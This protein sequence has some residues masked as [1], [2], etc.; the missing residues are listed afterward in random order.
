MTTTMLDALGL[1]QAT[2]A[3]TPYLVTGTCT[4]ANADAALLTFRYAGQ[5]VTGVIPV[6]EQ[7]PGTVW[8]PGTVATVLLCEPAGTGVPPRLSAIRTELVTETMASLSPEVRNGTVRIM[9]VARRP[10]QRTKVAV[11]ST[12]AEVDP[13]AACVGRAHNRVDALRAALG[14]EQVDIIAWHPEREMFL[15]NALQPAAISEIT[16]DEQNR[17]A[18]AVAPVHQMSAAVGG[19]GLNSALAGKLV[20]LLVRIVAQG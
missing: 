20:G 5:S 13:V 8:A 14:G 7:V 19:G 17:S 4:S 1:D 15:R 12:V 3:F 16:I 2:D 6:T 11:A 9:G 18:T 10:G